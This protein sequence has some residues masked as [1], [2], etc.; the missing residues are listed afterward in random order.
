VT[1]LK[2]IGVLAGVSI[3]ALIGGGFYL[4]YKAKK[5]FKNLIDE[6]KDKIPTNPEKRPSGD[7]TDDPSFRPAPSGFIMD[8]GDLPTDISDAF[9]ELFPDFWPPD[10]EV[11]DNLTEQDVIVVAV[12]SEPV[13]NYTETRQ[14]A[15]SAK[16]LSVETNVVRAR[17]IGPVAYAEHHGSH[18]G[19]GFR[20]GDLVEVPRSKVLL[21]AKPTEKSKLEYDGYG[22]AAQTL[23]PTELTKLTYQVRPGTPYDL[24][25]PYRTD[26]L[27]WHVDRD[28]VK[29]IYLGHNGL[30]EQIMFTE[31]SMRGPV[32]VRVQ[33][34]DQKEGLVHVA[35]WDFVIAP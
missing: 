27:D 35:R 10:D 24:V 8:K 18:A 33:D 12:Q 28:M 7:E 20:V 26:E 25:L 17:I 6:V 19:H 23:K 32:T 14:E 11:I 30:I 1:V 4:A 13:G 31:D 34:R 3:I 5:G 15:I 16:V 21:A 29:L 22:K 2:V 9:D